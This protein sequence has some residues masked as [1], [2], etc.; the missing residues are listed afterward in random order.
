MKYFLIEE[1]DLVR[2]KYWRERFHSEN[3][4]SGDEMRDAG[5]TLDQIIRTSE[6][7]EVPDSELTNGK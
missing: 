7:L 6:L 2:L 4:M 1:N 5:H 3:R